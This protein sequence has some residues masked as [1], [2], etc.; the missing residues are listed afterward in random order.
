M[1]GEEANVVLKERLQF[2]TSAQQVDEFLKTNP[3]SVV[4][5]AGTCHKTQE[6]FAQVQPL[7]EARPDL[8]VAIIRVVE[9]RAASNRMAEL[10][11]VRHQ[12]PQ[13]LLFSSGRAVFDRDNWEITGPAVADALEVHLSRPPAAAWASG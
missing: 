6:T 11:G 7:L 9:A 4:F 13:F 1:A 3:Q 12:S 2:L 10:S 8:P 5:K